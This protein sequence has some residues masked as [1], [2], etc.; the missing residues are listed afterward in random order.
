[1]TIIKFNIAEK[2]YLTMIYKK[3]ML[4]VMKENKYEC[5][6]RKVYAKMA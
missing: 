4:F 2:A 1:M 5:K 3:Y 6:K